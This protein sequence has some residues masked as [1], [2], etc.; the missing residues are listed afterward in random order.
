MPLLFYVHV[1]T[2]SILCLVL[3]KHQ[4]SKCTAN[5]NLCTYSSE[6]E[7]KLDLTPYCTCILKCKK[8]AHLVSDGFLHC[9]LILTVCTV[10]V[11]GSG[12][13][14]GLRIGVVGWLFVLKLAK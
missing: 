2:I 7:E 3:V 9:Y 1:S 14:G 6:N 13:G 11:F 4:L 5:H 12:G 8:D 10:C